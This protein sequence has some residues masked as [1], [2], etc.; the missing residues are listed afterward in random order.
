[1]G[2]DLAESTGGSLDPM[3]ITARLWGIADTSPYMHDGR[4]LSLADAIEMH[5]GDGASARDS[6][7]SLNRR[8]KNDLLSFLRILRTPTEV[9]VGLDVRSLR[10]PFT[11]FGSGGQTPP[12][13]VSTGGR[14]RR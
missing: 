7:R 11:S 6:Y 2:A 8:R 12:R 1:M 9:A 5:G 14:I 13:A 4:A 3:F 10:R